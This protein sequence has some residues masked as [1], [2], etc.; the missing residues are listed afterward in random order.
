MKD[1]MPS[2]GQDFIQVVA[3]GMFI[4]EHLKEEG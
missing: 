4:H 2:E 3:I 1:K